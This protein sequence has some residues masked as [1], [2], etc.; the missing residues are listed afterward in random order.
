MLKTSWL[1]SLSTRLFSSPSRRRSPRRLPVYAQVERLESRVLLSA[2]PLVTS[3]DRVGP[4]DTNA[5]SV[6][7]TVTFSE[8]VQGVNAADFKV[9]TSGGVDANATV[10][11]TPV[12]GSV[13]TVSVTGVTGNGVVGLDIVD[14]NSIHDADG[15]T[16]IGAGITSQL[17]NLSSGQYVD[18]WQVSSDGTTIVY[19]VAEGNFVTSLWS[20]S[21][22]Q[23][24]AVE[25]STP[26]SPSESIYDWRLSPDGKHVVF[27]VRDNALGYVTSVWMSPTTGG[28]ASELIGSLSSNDIVNNWQ[29]NSTGTSVLF[30]I[31][32]GN[33]GYTTSIWSASTT[34]GSAIQLNTPL[35]ASESINNW[36]YSEDGARILFTV[37]DYSVY[38]T[39]A[40]WAAPSSG[41]AGTQLHQLS[42]PNQNINNWQFAGGSN[43]VFTVYDYG[44]GVQSELWL[45]P[46]GGTATL[47]NGPLGP[48]ESISWNL[49]PD[50]SV[51]V[52]TIYDN[53]TGMTLSLW[54]VPT[55]GGTPTELQAAPAGGTVDWQ[56]SYDGT[57]VLWAVYD[58]SLNQF[59][60]L[61]GVPLTGGAATMLNPLLGPTQTITSWD[62]SQP[63]A[64][65]II[66][67]S[68]TGLT[69]WVTPTTGSPAVQLSIPIAS[70]EG[71]SYWRFS[72]DGSQ[73]LVGIHDNS[74]AGRTTS[75][76]SSP[77]TGGLATQIT[78]PLA[79]DESINNAEFSPNG[80]YIVVTVT[81]STTGMT[82]SLWSAPVTGGSATQL[83]LPFGPTESLYDW[84]FAPNGTTIFYV[85]YDSSRGQPV[86]LWSV[87]ITGATSAIQLSPPLG[88][89]EYLNWDWTFSGNGAWMIF[90]VYDWSL[91]YT[92]S[93]WAG[94]AAGGP[95]VDLMPPLGPNEIIWNINSAPDRNSLVITVHDTSTSTDTSLWLASAVAGTLTKLTPAL[96][97]TQAVGGWQFDSEGAQVAFGIYDSTVGQNTSLWLAPT[98]GGPAV[99][100]NP[101]L[102]PGESI[103]NWSFSPDG[104]NLAF[105]IN[106]PMEWGAQLWVLP[107]SAG[108]S[109]TL[110]KSAS[111]GETINWSWNGGKE[112]DL[113]QH[114]NGTE[115]DSVLVYRVQETRNYN[116]VEIGTYS[117]ANGDVTGP[118]YTIDQIIPTV[119]IAPSSSSPIT[120]TTATFTVTFSE[121][122]QGV[123]AD[124]FALALSGVAVANPIVVT[125]VNG[126]VYTV[127]ISGISGN[128]TLGVNLVNSDHSVQD[129]ASN[130][131]AATVGGLLTVNQPGGPVQLSGTTLTINGDSLNNVITVTEGGSLTVVV[132]GISYLYTPSQVT[133]IVINGNDG[134][135]TITVNSLLAGTALTADGGNNNDT[136]KVAASVMNAVTLVGGAGNDL[137]VGGGGDDSLSGGSGNDWVNGGEGSD[138]LTG[139]IGN[140]VYAFDNAASNQI[141]T[142]VELAG[143]G[144]DLL[145][146]ATLTTG[147]T[148]DLNSIT[149]LATM[150]HRIVVGGA[151]D[152]GANFENIT[153]GS[154]NDTLIGNAA[155]N[156][157]TGNGGNDTLSGL[158]GNDQLDGGD[159]ND[160]LLGGLGSDLLKGGIG[161]D[162]LNGGDGYNTLIG[163]Q[164]GDVYAFDNATTNQVD[165][166][167][168]QAGEGTDTLNFASMTDNV[169]ANLTSDTALA[170]MAHR[171]VQTGGAGQAANF[172]NAYG[173][174]G[175]DTLIGNAANNLLMGNGGS[176]VL[177]GGGGNDELHGGT[178]RNILIGGA[179]SD[180]L[181]G[182]ADQDV[183]LSDQYNNQ[184]NPLALQSMLVEWVQA[185]PYQTRIDHL[186]GT[187]P[188]GANGAY[189]FSS[190][191]VSTDGSIDYLTGNG[192]QDW[193]LANS[194][195]DVLNDK[196]V[197][198]VFTH[199]DTWV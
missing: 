166:V 38:R 122:V 156:V 192:G 167:V 102:G 85:V 185:T 179:G 22:A 28:A 157:L 56:F 81:N 131:V 57:H 114:E 83:T 98:T 107:L 152:Q 59:T 100:I 164:G 191:T 170:T 19:T 47:L 2:S 148:A 55:S 123:T 54:M 20:A 92:A 127:S 115:Q 182:G 169:T 36:E 74:S 134:N 190:S 27:D 6:D 75:V 31:Y 45:A 50:Q 63:Q 125:P 25:V 186:L 93:I 106:T 103:G 68:T 161:N 124:D 52:Y 97:P 142:V 9:L 126:H 95:A 35:G 79:S 58:S 44:V 11:V 130:V 88:P 176:N 5:V 181:L 94:P 37:Y 145:N 90:S 159:G 18:G 105:S 80:T 139:G 7:Y 178:G 151:S 62:F 24:P 3:I 147:V 16:L 61:W 30:T 23:G 77:I 71:V 51:L 73:I 132:D 155:N 65:F 84:H 193:F 116:T 175:T 33:V 21:T 165:T 96:S 72:N 188:G 174:S 143:E 1:R 199:T 12:S 138:V 113:L 15:H 162:W 136:I 10:N 180:V 69:V 171:I 197:D 158:A 86:S 160:T 110:V 104:N 53:S 196:A 187:T 198:E 26:L 40:I 82:T 154:G 60:S 189:V 137:L 76:W 146:F 117:A 118:T 150:A 13:Y 109:A 121:D 183:L 101:P 4:V 29:F 173:G 17:S 149:A 133:A 39:A 91:G 108:A 168:E 67:D 140:D 43:I 194:A 177:S 141:D 78:V 128:G 66:T 8:T 99:Q 184:T 49:S 172:E 144:T 41:A 119:T 70:N 34:G 153:G 111:L 64:T 89:T 135:D 112:I 87:P 48:S 32:D 195:Q 129:A 46:V 14:D 163:G 120:G 42:D